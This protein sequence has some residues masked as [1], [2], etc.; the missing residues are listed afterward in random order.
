MVVTIEVIRE[1]WGVWCRSCRPRVPSDGPREG[2]E[3]VSVLSHRPFSLSSV[4]DPV[5]S[6]CPSA[7]ESYRPVGARRTR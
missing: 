7:T 6:P 4:A 5:R 1:V 3:R 2:H